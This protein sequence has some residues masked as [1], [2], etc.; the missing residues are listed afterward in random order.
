MVLLEINYQFVTNEDIIMTPQDGVYRFSNVN[1]Y[2][3]TL[4][5]YRYTVDSTDV[6]QKFIIPN[7]NAVP[8][9]IVTV[10][11]EA[12]FKSISTFATGDFADVGVYPNI[13][14]KETIF[15]LISA[16]SRYISFANILALKPR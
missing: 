12:L 11:P 6:D 7:V 2:E 4:A 1:I 16:E 14:A 15:F 10:A 9:A 13:F 5:T 8:F 3:G